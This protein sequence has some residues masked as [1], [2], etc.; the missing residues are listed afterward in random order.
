MSLAIIGT[1]DAAL[2]VEA[3]VACHRWLRLCRFK[4]SEK[5]NKPAHFQCE[6]TSISQNFFDSNSNLQVF[7]LNKSQISSLEE[8]LFHYNT[9]L[10]KIQIHLQDNNIKTLPTILIRNYPLLE[11]FNA[12]RNAIIECHKY[13]KKII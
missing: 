3:T 12:S 11:T 1:S 4:S 8:N 9:L 7:G 5:P 2:S 10:K 6:I 13:S